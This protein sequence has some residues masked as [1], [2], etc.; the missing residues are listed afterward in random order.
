MWIKKKEYLK[1]K[2]KIAD[3]ERD[4]DI[5]SSNNIYLNDQY[6]KIRSENNSLQD[7]IKKKSSENIQLQRSITTTLETN[8]TLNNWIERILNDV[9]IKE[10]HERT[11]VTIPVY[12]Q[13]DQ[14]SP[15]KAA[16]CDAPFVR[17]RKEIIIPEL[18][19]VKMG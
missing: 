11:G 5:L 7:D 12:I 1:M 17:R 2:K 19:F 13:D 16:D 10:L 6:E 14:G 9:G 8:N 18:R 4:N 3:L 15:Y